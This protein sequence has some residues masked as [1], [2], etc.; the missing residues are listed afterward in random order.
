MSQLHAENQ[1]AIELEEI[2]LV[3]TTEETAVAVAKRMHRGMSLLEIMV[4]I[5][6]IGLVTADTRRLQVGLKDLCRHEWELWQDPSTTR[7]MGVVNLGAAALAA[8]ARRSGIDVQIESPTV[9]SAIL[10]PRP[11]PNE[12]RRPAGR[13]RS[14]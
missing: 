8:L 6:L 11:R 14:S 13:R 9:P 7:G 5:T 3:E 10:P 1:P 2:E 12:K 4:V